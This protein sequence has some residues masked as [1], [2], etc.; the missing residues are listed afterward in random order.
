MVNL[1][2][3]HKILTF[4]ILF[5]WISVVIISGRGYSLFGWSW[6]FTNTGAFG[7][8]FGPI[9]AFMASLAA[10]SAIG[11][12]K[13]QQSEIQRQK[14]REVV[15]DERAEK[16]EFEATFFRLL[17]AFRA[18]VSETDILG[19]EGNN[20]QAR[21]AFKAMLVKFQRDVASTHTDRAAWSKTSA[22]YRNDLNHYFRFLYHLIVFVDRSDQI[23]RYFYIRFV[24]AL[25]SEAELTLIALNCAHGEGTEKFKPLVEKYA[26][27]HNLSQ[28]AR[29]KWKIVDYYEPAAFDMP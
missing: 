13:S 27:L 19:A 1:N 5:V 26:L 7:D 25:L 29:T 10:L 24:R 16:K 17:D 12:Y 21:D 9:S 22:Y 18:I 28:T 8:S 14:D 15:D 6:N 20:R 11:A 4:T 23:D 3:K 2:R